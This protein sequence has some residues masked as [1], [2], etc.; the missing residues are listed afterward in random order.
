MRL[1]LVDRF[2]GSNAA[3]APFRELEK[4]GPLVAGLGSTDWIVDLVLVDDEVMSEL[5]GFYRGMPEVTDVL[6]FSYL[7]PQG[8]GKADIVRGARGAHHD[9]WL[10]PLDCHREDAEAGSEP[11]NRTGGRL[12]GELIFAPDFVTSRC[13]VRGWPLRGEL[14]LLV[15]HGCLHLLGWEHDQEEETQAMRDQEMRLLET[16]GLR[17]P[18]I[19]D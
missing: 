13:K 10:D 18:L 5:N 17:H 4:L 2:G 8:D 1:R 3:A 7:L 14:P 6:S 9:F 15:V 16:A 12:I 19:P 11:G